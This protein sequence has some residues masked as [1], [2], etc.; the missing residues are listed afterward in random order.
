MA[1]DWK[2]ALEAMRNALPQEEEKK[3][4]NMPDDS[5]NGENSALQTAPLHIAIEKKGRKGK[6]ATIIYGFECDDD[7]LSGIASQIKKRTGTGG[8]SRGGE[9]LLQG[10]WREKG[11]EILRGMGY[12]VR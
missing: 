7:T 11:A 1:I 2:D 4:I 12:K 6:T 9:I 3:E 8:S 10:D 5:G